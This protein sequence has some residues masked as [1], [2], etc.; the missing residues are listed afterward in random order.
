M[1]DLGSSLPCSSI[2]PD[3]GRCPQ[4]L[5]WYHSRRSELPGCH[6][7]PV[8]ALHVDALHAGTS[9]SNPM[10]RGNSHPVAL[11]GAPSAYQDEVLPYGAVS[12]GARFIGTCFWMWLCIVDGER[13]SPFAFW[14][15]YA[16]KFVC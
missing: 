11:M 7:V 16:E 2:S 10:R 14:V 13:P 6:A 9:L 3:A 15:I 5:S 8:D 12:P 4:Q 1:Y